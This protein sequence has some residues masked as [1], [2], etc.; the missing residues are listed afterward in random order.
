MSYFARGPWSTV[1]TLIVDDTFEA[2]AYREISTDSTRRSVTVNWDGDYRQGRE[3]NV[4]HLQGVVDRDEPQALVF[5]L[6]D[7]AGS[8]T[9]RAAWPLNFRDA[10]GIAPFVIIGARLRDEPD[11]EAVVSQRLPTHAAPGFYVSRD[12]SLATERDMRRWKL[13]PVRT[14]AEDFACNGRI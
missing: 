3:L 11:I 8:T 5:S 9:A 14:T 2:A 13:I 6:S 1:W 10:Y 4:V 7:Y 12:I